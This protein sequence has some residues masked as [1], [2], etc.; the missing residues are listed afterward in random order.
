M[1]FKWIYKGGIVKIQAYPELESETIGYRAEAPHPKLELELLNNKYSELRFVISLDNKEFQI[2]PDLI[3]LLCILSYYPFIEESVVFPIPVSIKFAKAIRELRFF[4]V[5]DGEYRKRPDGKDKIQVKNIDL[6]LRPWTPGKKLSLAYGG[7]LDSTATLALFQDV[8]IIHEAREGH[9]DQTRTFLKRLEH[10]WIKWQGKTLCIDSNNKD[11]TKNLPGGWCTW[12]ACI[13]TSILLAEVLDLG[14]ILL[15]SSL[16]SSYLSG[17]KFH[18]IHEYRKNEWQKLF[19]KLDLKVFSP[20]AGLSE[21]ALGKVLSKTYPEW[22]TKITYCY[23]GKD[24]GNC[25]KCTKC[26]RREVIITYLLKNG[27]INWKKYEKILLKLGS[28]KGEEELRKLGPSFNLALS[29]I[30][31]NNREAL[32]ETTFL[33]RYYSPALKLVPEELRTYCELRIKKYLDKMSD[34]DHLCLQGYSH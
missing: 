19:D 28:E 16:G 31:S 7:G 17:A 27:E 13:S 9:K 32:D 8:F 26:F 10:D 18:P 4:T 6:N 11:L 20:I 12:V 29:R 3:A 33:V 5:V 22:L 23:S 34:I 1:K 25:Y 24:G 14:Y 30:M 15:G 21:I 2:H